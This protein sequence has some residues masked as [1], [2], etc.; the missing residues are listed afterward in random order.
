MTISF[1]TQFNGAPNYFIDKIWEAIYRNHLIKHIDESHPKYLQEH[2]DRFGHHWDFTPEDRPRLIDINEYMP[3]MK[4]NMSQGMFVTL[5]VK[6]PIEEMHFTKIHSIRK[7]SRYQAGSILHPVI[8]NRSKD[9]FQ[10]AP[11]IQVK[12]IQ[13]IKIEWLDGED[14]TERICAVSIDGNHTGAAQFK[15][16]SLQALS[17][18]LYHLI[19]CDGFERAIDFFE[20]FHEDFEGD[21]VHWTEWRY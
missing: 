19:K 17:L 4:G 18:S 8:N 6:T 9:R 21:I 14:N 13:K 16:C 10:F 15:N 2:H 11:C 7:E 1:Q 3:D 20:W 5:P 12:S